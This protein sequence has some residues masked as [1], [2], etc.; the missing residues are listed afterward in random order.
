MDSKIAKTL[1]DFKSGRIDRRRILRALGLTATAGLAASVM[2]R[3]V[4]VIAAQ[5]ATPAGRAFPVT[6]VNHLSYVATDYFKTRDWYID[7]FGMRVVWDDG[8]GCALEFGDVKSPN[9][10][11]IR[12]LYNSGD[13]PEINHIAFGIPNFMI[14]KEAMKVEMERWGLK[15]IR[16]DGE[17]G[18]IAD[19]PAGY[20]LNTWV[21][22]KDPA[23][24]PGAARPCENA[25]SAQCKAAYKSGLKN[26]DKLPKPSGRGFKATSFSHIVLNVPEADLSKERDFYRDLLGMKVIYDQPAD[27]AKN[28]GPQVFLR[29][30]RNTLYLRPTS[31][32]GEKPYCNHFAFVVENYDQNK[33]EAEL[34]RR[35]LN[36]KPDSKLAWTIADPD[37]FRIEVAGWGLPEHIANDCKGAN[38]SCAGGVRG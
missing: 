11:Y 30:G 20:M 37:G 33:V 15:N 22:E 29:F 34:N 9:G 2:P 26:L 24:F 10:I 7:L 28:Q 27:P 17:H 23:M 38:S 4:D 1:K 25:E 6:T 32:P 31:D 21:P 18:W 16:A 14:H 36:P 13:K 5:A 8:K 35:G 3:A 12:S 19:D